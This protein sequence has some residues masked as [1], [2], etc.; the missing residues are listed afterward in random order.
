MPLSTN[1]LQRYRISSNPSCRK[2]PISKVPRQPCRF[3]SSA[4]V[5]PLANKHRITSLP[6][7]LSQPS[8]SN[9]TPVS[10]SNDSSPRSSLPSAVKS[11]CQLLQLLSQLYSASSLINDRCNCFF[12]NGNSHFKRLNENHSYTYISRKSFQL[13]KNGLT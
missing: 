5:L 3:E 10:K 2:W 11:R 7:R 9:V 1:L 13:K 4:H 8:P 12:S 6:G